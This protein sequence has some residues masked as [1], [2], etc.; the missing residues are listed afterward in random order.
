MK[1]ATFFLVLLMSGCAVA[2]P[3]FQITDL[4]SQQ[5]YISE[6]PDIQRTET[7]VIFKDEQSGRTMKIA[8][9]EMRRIN[10]ANYVPHF[11][12]HTGQLIRDQKVDGSP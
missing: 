7:G 3:R 6:L 5:A 8:R 10:D 4:D 12:D 11:D 1:P 9:Y 2:V